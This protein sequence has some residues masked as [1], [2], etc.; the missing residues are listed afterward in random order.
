MRIVK[1]LVRLPRSAGLPEPSLIMFV[2]WSTFCV[3]TLPCPLIGYYVECLRPDTVNLSQEE[4]AVTMTTEILEGCE[5]T[6]IRAGIIGEIGCN[7]PLQGK[8]YFLCV[9]G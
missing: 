3:V 7:W 2:T 6:G 8:E 1:A 4:M 5:G 9:L